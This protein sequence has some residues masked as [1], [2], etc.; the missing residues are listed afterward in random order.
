[1][2]SKDSKRRAL[3]SWKNVDINLV[4]LVPDEDKTLGGSLV[5]MTSHAHTSIFSEFQL[6]GAQ[7][8]KTAREKKPGAFF[9][10]FFA[11]RFSGCAP[12]N[13]TPGRGKRTTR[14]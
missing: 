12:A 2:V 4:P 5:F 14:V 1:M 11:R 6:V 13:W 9:V 8:E 10:Y 3:L 7:R